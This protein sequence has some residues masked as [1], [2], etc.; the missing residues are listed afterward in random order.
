MM[1]TFSPHH[2]R[3][4]PNPPAT[5][6]EEL[7]TPQH[8][9]YLKACTSL[10]TSTHHLGVLKDFDSSN[11]IPNAFKPSIKPLVQQPTTHLIIRWEQAINH[12]CHNFIYILV[13]HWQHQVQQ[14]EKNTG[15][16][17]TENL[18][19]YLI[20]IHETDPQRRFRPFC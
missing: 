3:S 12:L 13:E 6:L 5:R 20:N 18:R 7:Y 2:K 14:N 15:F 8:K 9:T 17:M 16:T 1:E 19:R 11:H 10:A 4:N